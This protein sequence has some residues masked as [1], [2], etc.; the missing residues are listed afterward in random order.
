[1]GSSKGTAP[2]PTTTT[3]GF[4][5]QQLPLALRAGGVLANNT[6]GKTPQQLVPAMSRGTQQ[7]LA[8]LQTFGN[9]ANP[10]TQAGIAG[11][12][13]VADQTQIPQLAT[14]QFTKTISGE[15]MKANPFQNEVVQAAMRPMIDQFRESTAPGISARFAAAG[16]SGSP[17]EYAT[18]YRAEDA[19]AKNLGE[20]AARIG[21]QDYATERQN[22][23]GMLDQAGSILNLQAAPAMMQLQAGEARDADRL[24]RAQALLQAGGAVDDFNN[25]RVN[26]KASAAERLLAALRGSGGVQSSSQQVERNRLGGAVGGAASGAMMGATVGGPWGAVIGGGLGAIG[27]AFG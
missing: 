17:S 5:P 9:T 24:Q 19:L 15:Y 8:Q 27:G 23:L 10:G 18:A 16:R 22:Q 21:Y 25:R 26:A 7:G 13:D 1:M 4:L 3:T 6:L 2:G 20:T 12:M 11:L 14:D